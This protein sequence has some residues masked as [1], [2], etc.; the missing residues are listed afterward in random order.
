MYSVG[1]YIYVYIERNKNIFFKGAEQESFG[2]V[3]YVTSARYV[4]ALIP[5]SASN[6]EQ[7]FARRSN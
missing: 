3:S 7:R 1:V 4:A 5:A 6:G 2:Q